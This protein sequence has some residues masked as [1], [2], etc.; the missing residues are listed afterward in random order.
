MA[1]PNGEDFFI[2]SVPGLGQPG[3]GQ[4]IYSRSWSAWGRVFIQNFK[5]SES[6]YFRSGLGQPEVVQKIPMRKQILI[7]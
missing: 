6:V 3:T 4:S 2:L 7:S 5:S 1:N